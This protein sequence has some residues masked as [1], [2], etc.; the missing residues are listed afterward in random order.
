MLFL[1]PKSL[2]SLTNLTNSLMTVSLYI[3]S[4]LRSLKSPLPTVTHEELPLLFDKSF[5]EKLSTILSTLPTP[6]I[7]ITPITFPLSLA[8]F[9]SPPFD[10]IISLLKS[11]SSTSSLDPLPLPI[12]KKIINILQPPS[13][14]HLRF[15]FFRLRPSRFQK[16]SHYPYP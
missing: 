15:T 11:T 16:S 3:S 12:L 5:N 1:P 9:E 7:P 2:T 10:Q 4:Q 14:N 8:K 6:V 13:S